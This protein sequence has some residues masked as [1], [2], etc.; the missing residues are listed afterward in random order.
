[1]RDWH[2]Q[3]IGIVLTVA[4]LTFIAFL[5]TTEPRSLAEVT[6]K[7]SVVIGTYE[8]DR[9][10]FDEG[11]ASFRKDE[12]IAARDAF[13]RADPERR[14]AATQFYVA[15]S[16]YHQ[17]WGRFTNDDTLFQTGIEAVNRVSAI[18]PNYR[19]A[20]PS[21]VMKTPVELR[22]ELEEGLKV[23]ADDFNPMKLTRERK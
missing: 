14:D 18:D 16:Y 1:M 2:I 6:T 10:K 19:V 11:L 9:A 13:E 4:G 20:D 23:T 7:G 8:I 5:Y 17:G 15:Y 22:T 21:L 3:I 12:F